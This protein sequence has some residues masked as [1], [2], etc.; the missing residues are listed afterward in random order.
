MSAPNPE[1]LADALR[2]AGCDEACVLRML[3]AAHPEHDELTWIRGAVAT[4]EACI[5]AVEGIAWGGSLAT[6]GEVLG[7]INLI[8]LLPMDLRSKGSAP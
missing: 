2:E 5:R 4:R 1:V 7:R 6:A 8:D 3:N